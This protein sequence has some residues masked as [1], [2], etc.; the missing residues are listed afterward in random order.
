MKAKA[1]LKVAQAA[2]SRAKSEAAVAS[3]ERARTDKLVEQGILSRTE[4]EAIAATD[5]SAKANVASARATLSQA[6]AALEQA[7]T[8]LRYAVIVSPIDGVV[9]SRDV[10]MG[11][12]LAASMTP[13]ILFTIAE[14]L[15]KMEVHTS[16]AEADVGQVE[17]GMKVEF[18]VDAH[19]GKT[20]TGVVKEVRFAPTTVQ[21]VVTYD[22]VVSIENP[23]LRLRPGMTAQVAFIAEE[24]PG[25][26]AVPNA[27]LRFRP[28]VAGDGA[29]DAPAKSDTKR[30]RGRE[31]AGRSRTVYV[32]ADGRLE[33]R[34][35]EIGLADERATEIV[36]GELGEG[37]W[38]V[39]GMETPVGEEAKAATPAQG[40]RPQG[41]SQ[42]RR[43]MGGRGG[44]L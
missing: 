17:A 29:G 16:V 21:N 34:E 19:P 23:E 22:A 7:Q 31:G 38:V 36:A 3:S 37:E 15:R 13:P 33:A 32:L 9:I 11:Q 28:P 26:L 18:T 2:L 1:S 39:T 40:Q 35:I 4:Q 24:R 43:G 30:A 44:F 12:P 41:P 27:A 14:D 25:A 20:F 6:E 8:N 42:Q 10:D 5:L